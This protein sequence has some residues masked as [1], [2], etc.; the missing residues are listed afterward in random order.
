MRG[1]LLDHFY[2]PRRGLGGYMAPTGSNPLTIFGF[3]EILVGPETHAN[4]LEQTLRN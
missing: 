3:I 4:C 2:A 1:C